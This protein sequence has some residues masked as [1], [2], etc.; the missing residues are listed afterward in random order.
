MK[1]DIGFIGL[2]VM[3]ENLVLNMEHHGFTVAVFNRTTA[4]V[5]TFIN[6]RAQGKK[7]IGTRSLAEL[8]QSIS[9]PRKI[10]M[11]IKAGAAVDAV[12]DELI[13]LLEEGDIL[14]D[15]G[16]SN[17]AD[18]VRRVHR[19][20]ALGIRFVGTGVSGGE[21]GALK[22]PSIMPGGEAEAWP[23]IRNI[24]TSIAAKGPDGDP[25][26]AWIGPDGSGHY[27]KMIHN[28]IEYGDMQLLA[29][30]YWIMREYL[31]MNH[32][33]M[34]DVFSQWNEGK[35]DSYLVEITAEILRKKDSDG[36]PLALKILDTAGQKGTGKWTGIAAL[37]EGT[38]LT[39]ITESVFARALSSQKERRVAASRI[40]PVEKKNFDGDRNA[41]LD[42]LRDA[43]YAAKIV[44]YAQGFELIA[45]ASRTNG[46]NLDFAGI[47]RLWRGGCIIRSVFL[48]RIADAFTANPELSNLVESPYFS[49]ELIRAED[50]WRKTAAAAISA[51]LPVPALASALTWF[52]GY[53][54]AEG[55]ANLIQAQRDYFGAHTYERTDAE[56]GRF[57]HTDWTGHGGSAISGSYSV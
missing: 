36:E 15:G 35:L 30:T 44:S 5:D 6:G 16:N 37:N 32:D 55:P 40:F 34:A 57:F 1:A 50:G 8:T 43:L 52:D 24:F 14:I 11:M 42:A 47:A 7:I 18:T 12:I 21:E 20:K 13:P 48:D 53:R 29:E 17:Y 49:G 51:S 31:G 4:T 33:E 22:G 25:C 10:M 3:G 28:G 41:M 27:V 39:L 46:W 26:C 45:Q 19:L 23:E 54:S 56:R 9:R 2:A 38:P